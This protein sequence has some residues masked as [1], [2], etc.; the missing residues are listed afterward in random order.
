MA[1]IYIHIPFCRHACTYCDFHFS[2]SFAIKNELVN[3][4]KQE[5]VLQK[6]YLNEKIETIYFGGGTPSLLSVT[7]IDDILKTVYSNFTVDLMECTLEANPDDLTNEY[8]NQLIKTKVNRL[9]IGIQSF[10]DAVLKWMNRA[11]NKQVAFGAVENAS[12]SGFEKISVDLIYATPDSSVDGLKRNLEMA[13]SLP[14]NH[15]SAYCL[16]AEEKTVYGK[17][18]VTGKISELDH[19]NARE[20]FLFLTQTAAEMGFEQYEISNFCKEENYALHNSNYWKGKTYLG[21]GPSAHSYNGNSRQWNVKSNSLYI[22]AMKEKSTFFECEE[23]TPVNKINEYIM[24]SLRTKWGADLSFIRQNTPDA[25]LKKLNNAISH[26]IKNR[27]L[28][29]ANDVLFIPSENKFIADRII[30]DLF[31]G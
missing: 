19:E 24:T 25:E 9:S 20:Q 2:T 4:I 3:A 13:L 17:Q 12:K 23:L 16:T 22:K 8:L 5:I 26:A 14:I 7:E 15:L 6:N 27:L 10:D 1:G 11:H 29:I 31:L 30:S 18:V 28:I 21:I